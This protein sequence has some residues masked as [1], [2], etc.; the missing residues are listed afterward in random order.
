MAAPKFSLHSL[1]FASALL[2]LVVLVGG[3]LGV[4]Y[5]ANEEGALTTAANLAGVIESNIRE[6][7]HRAESDSEYF[8]RLMRPDDFSPRLTD[9]RRAEIEGVLAEHLATF[10]QISHYRIF[11]ANGDLIIRGGP[12][13]IK[14]NVADRDWFQS[15][16]EDSGRSLIISDVITAKTTQLPAVVMAVPIRDASNRFLGAV[17]AVIDLQYF[18]T[19]ID[20]PQIGPH[21]FIAVRRSDSTRLVLR[22][23]AQPEQINEPLRSPILDR[24]MAGETSGRESFVSPMDKTDRVYAFRKVKKFPFVIVVGLARQDFMATWTKQAMFAGVAAIFSSGILSGLYLFQRRMQARLA[25][26]NHLLTEGEKRYRTLLYTGRDGIHVL[27]KNGNLV[28]ANNSFLRM[29]GYSVAEAK[30]LNVRDWDEQFSFGMSG[31]NIVL[32]LIQSPKIFQT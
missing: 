17:S 14:L 15:L 22:Q 32:E 7:F 16:R 5:R 27:D 6:V 24:V 31:E 23:P 28:E 8:A 3:L 30:G 19:V 4:G 25:L 10:G 26:S 21:G 1:L 9:A 2:V 29:L 12:T 13:Q 20:N 11:D 18:Q